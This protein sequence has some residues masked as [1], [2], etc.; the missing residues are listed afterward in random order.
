MSKRRSKPTVERYRG[1]KSKVLIATSS[2]EQHGSESA[3]HRRRPCAKLILALALLKLGTGFCLVKPV[4]P[5]DT[6]LFESLKSWAHSDA[7]RL[8]RD[9][10][11]AGASQR[12]RDFRGALVSV[13][14]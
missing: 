8:N 12:G 14:I 13:R 3:G 2:L 5:T 9:P 4:H 10:A 6:T 11:R 1:E 7:L